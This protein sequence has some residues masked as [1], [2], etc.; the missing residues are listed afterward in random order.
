M[1]SELKYFILACLTLTF[2]SCEALRRTEKV[3]EQQKSS[4]EVTNF[5]DGWLFQRGTTATA[6][7]NGEWEE[8]VLPHTVKIEPLVVND[9]WQGTSLYRK[10]FSVGEI[11]K[12][13]WFFHFEGVMQEA[14]VYINESL[15]ETHKG[16]YL[17]FTID[18]TTHLKENSLNRMEVEVTNVDDPTIPPGKPLADLDFNYYGGIYRN[19]HLIKTG[20]IY[21]TDAVE[22]N[23]V[24]GGGILVHF[25]SISAESASGFVKV[26]VRNESDENRD[27]GLRIS[28]V[29]EGGLKKTFL[30]PVKNVI[31]KGSFHF[32]QDIAL[33]QPQLWSPTAPN[34]YELTVEV[35]NRGEVVDKISLTTGI[36]SIELKET[37]FILN[38]E[39]FFINGTNRHQE[40]PYVGYAL[41]DEANYRDAYKIKEAGFN[42]V[43]LSHYPHATSFLE[44]CDELGLL[45]MNAIPGWQFF[46]EG[47]FAENALQDIRDM[48]RRDRNHPSV[49]FWENSLNESGM[50]AAFIQKANE[51]LRAELPYNDVY[52][53]GWMDHPAYDL[54]IPARQHA[55]PPFYWNNYDKPGRPILIAEYGDWE[56]YAQNAGFNQKAFND[57]QE[58]ERTSR[59][60]RGAGEKRL[61][62]QALNFQEAT[63]SNLKGRQTIGMSNWLM[64]DY[65]RG[66]ADD[67]E[68]SGISDIFRIPKFSFYFYKSQKRPFSGAFSEPMVYIASYWQQ[69]SSTDITVYGNTEEVALY[70]NDSL[71]ERKQPSK[72]P[73][74]DELWSPPFKFEVE[75]FEAGALKA[76]G[77]IDGEEVATHLVQT[78][79]EPAKI[80]LS[81]DTSGRE[82]A[83]AHPDVVFVY[84]RILD[85][86][87]TLVPNANLP[88]SFTLEGE[89]AELLGENPKPA[90]AGIATILLKTKEFIEPLILKASVE[91][92]PAASLTIK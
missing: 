6:A 62:Q 85:R 31:S 67:L 19:V 59:Q 26:Q 12:E 82:I 45:V 56:Y 5:V 30:T 11:N 1:K 84:A 71:I 10:D 77:Y 14:R 83:T 92:L 36:R 44:A 61:L 79:L 66:Y 27:L 65:N 8:V 9:Q 24:N 32:V 4:R 50:T 53:A 68:A 69:A 28:M 2:F 52:T 73:F 91:G 46:A 55:K 58:E 64:F 54:F 39:E 89:D 15:V 87:G 33:K 35:L 80:E 49:V 41:S 42:F 51:V 22:A 29:S 17:P 21:I 48:A 43:R 38:G 18:A 3:G 75:S 16:G 57:L 88:V 47:E 78:P 63:N 86:N 20:N 70:L 25:D 76:V 90:E 37:A 34:L 13:K 23:E 40:Y 72:D 74:S 7:S 81:L 60:L